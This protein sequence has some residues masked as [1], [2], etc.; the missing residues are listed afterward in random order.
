MRPENVNSYVRVRIDRLIAF[1]YAK[2]LLSND[3]ELRD[4]FACLDLRIEIR[5]CTLARIYVH[6][7]TACMR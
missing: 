6:V 5:A 2:S 4:S 1:A 3:C 7:L